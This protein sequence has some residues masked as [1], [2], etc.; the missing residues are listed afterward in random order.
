MGGICFNPYGSVVGFQLV[1]PDAFRIR[2]LAWNLPFPAVAGLP[3]YCHGGTA[4]FVL[5]L[6]DPLS[7]VPLG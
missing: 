7:A 2:A 6:P 5:S 4:E 3:V 1:S